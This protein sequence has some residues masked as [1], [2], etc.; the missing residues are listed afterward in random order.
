M[1]G[2]LP[3]EVVVYARAALARAVFPGGRLAPAAVLEGRVYP[4]DL[5]GYGSVR[6]VL[7][8]VDPADFD[9]LARRLAARHR[10]Y[11]LGALYLASPVEA[12][13]KV[14][15]LG[16]NYRGHARETGRPVP[17]RPNVFALTW[18]SVA[19]PLDPVIIPGEEAKV[20]L[21]VELAV[22]VGRGVRGAPPEEAWE[23]VWGFAVA[24]DVSSRA[25]QFE[26]GVSQFWRAKSWD[27]Y[28]PLGP[29]VVPRPDLDPGSLRL[30]SR[31]NGRVMQDSTTAD[32][33]YGVAEVVA[34]AS[35]SATLEPGDVILTGTPEGVGHA[36]RP[37]VYLKDGDLVEAC[38]EGIGCLRNRVVVDRA[39]SLEPPVEVEE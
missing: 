4:L 25:E 20:D 38:V 32:M 24:N 3:F 7:V 5:E 28:T 2:R 22:V 19:G 14:L 13:V 39:L 34:Y 8:E 12:P 30:W 18:N 16:L 9:R 35:Q 23:A 1:E 29:V 36:R 17:P 10:G 33:V 6:E 15:G 11:P 21:E 27:T 26:A 37:P 31:L